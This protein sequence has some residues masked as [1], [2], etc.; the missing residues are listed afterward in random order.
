MRRDAVRMGEK[1]YADGTRR[2][3]LKAHLEGSNC[4]FTLVDVM[5][6]FGK[7]MD[8]GELPGFEY[9]PGKPAWQGKGLVPDQCSVYAWIG[10]KRA[11]T[12]L[13]S[14]G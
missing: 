9:L 10:W 13:T 8:S 4:Y 11:S 7:T 3:N 5:H 6:V 12:L 14:F 2:Y 1:R